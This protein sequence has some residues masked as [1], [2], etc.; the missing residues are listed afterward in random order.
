MEARRVSEG[1][2]TT[3]SH[4]QIGKA[5]RRARFCLAHASGYRTGATSTG[6]GFVVPPSGGRME[7]RRVSE[8]RITTD[9][10]LQIGRAGRRARFCLAHASGYRTGA[11]STEPGFVRE[12]VPPNPD[13]AGELSNGDTKCGSEGQPKRP[14]KHRSP[15]RNSDSSFRLPQDF[16][17]SASKVWLDAKHR[18]I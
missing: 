5:G 1:R 10:H 7:A 16:L 14:A 3:D 15:P 11:T 9:S 13:I 12:S 6:P 18:D 17:E 8:G 2:I 4:L